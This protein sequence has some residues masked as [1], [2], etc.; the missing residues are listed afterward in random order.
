MTESTLAITYTELKQSV[1]KYLGH[2]LNPDGWSDDQKTVIDMAIKKGLRQFYFPPQIY[3]DKQSHKWSFLTPV[4]TLET[5]GPYS[6]GTVSIGQYATGTVTVAT[7]D[8]TLLGGIWP[9]WVAS[10]DTLTI[11]ET[12]YAV[13][14]RDDDTG[15]TVVG[16]DV[17]TATAYTVVTQ[18]VT[19]AIAIVAGGVWPD[20]TELHGSIV[21]DTTEYAITTRDSDTELT[22]TNAFAAADYIEGDDYVLNHDGNYDLPDGFAGIVDRLVIESQNHES[23][24]AIV[25]EG[26]IRN[27]R[28]QNPQNVDSGSR[29]QPYYAAI[30]P[31]VQETTTGQ[32]F[33]IMFYPIM[34]TALTISYAMRLL[35]EMLVDTSIEYPYGGATHAD[36]ILASCLA[37][38]EVQIQDG[39]GP[40]W[41]A[42]KEALT[43][44]ITSDNAMNS[45][46]NFGYNGDN[47]DAIHRPYRNSRDRRGCSRGL[48][49]YDGGL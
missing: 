29:T 13:T 36:T 43:A 38:A 17:G 23:P 16:A 8:C 9:S 33:E 18:E 35:P 21:I 12:V 42:Y 1:A 30:R 44:S 24:I 19:S 5:V 47:S 31:K 10:G 45:V 40:L 11:G 25:G 7:G 26:V 14:S 4:T 27:S 34:S 46:Q 39:H 6:T 28:Q 32:R 37:A 48:V 49:T 41:V 15:L 2:G 22:L 20:W 3:E